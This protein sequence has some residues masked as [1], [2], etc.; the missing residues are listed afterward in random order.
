MAFMAVGRAWVSWRPRDIDWWT[1]AL[2]MLGSIAFGVSAV[3][4][5]VIVDSGL[6][7]NVER[8][9]LGTFIGAL[10]F[11]VGAFLL[12]PPDLARPD[13]ACA[14]ASGPAL[15]TPGRRGNDVADGPVDRR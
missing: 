5:Y 10:C 15:A 6:V 1:A 9:N 2:N 14:R 12:L 7:R 8:A 4:S 3:A 13:A 11:F